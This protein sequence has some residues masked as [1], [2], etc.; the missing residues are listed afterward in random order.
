MEQ[1]KLFVFAD[2]VKDLS[3]VESYVCNRCK[4][5]KPIEDFSPS[6]L[7]FHRKEKGMSHGGGGAMWCKECNSEYNKGKTIATNKAPPK[8]KV[9]TPCDCCGV[10]TDPTKLHL[11]HDHVTYE[12]R[13]FLCR[14]CNTGIGSLGDT[15]EGL[16]KAINYLK[17]TSNE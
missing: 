16:V 5:E 13:G 9:P 2:V 11:D 7:R 14:N 15:I 1:L 3:G 4:C 8:P 10:I 6:A 17:R 12:F